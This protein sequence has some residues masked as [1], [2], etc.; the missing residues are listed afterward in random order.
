MSH[1]QEAHIS[2]TWRSAL[3]CNGGGCVK[4]AVSGQT[5]FIG[6]TKEPSGPV[7]SYTP[8][9]WRDFVFGIKNGD[10]DDLIE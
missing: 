5:V 9:E 1:A 3:S 7:L 4:V 6:D 10:F 2:L 8:A